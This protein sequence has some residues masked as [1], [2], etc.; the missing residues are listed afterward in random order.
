MLFSVAGLIVIAFFLWR[1]ESEAYDTQ[2]QIANN[3]DQ[4]QGS[5]ICTG[6]LTIKNKEAGI[7]TGM[8]KRGT[9]YRLHMDTEKIS[10]NERYSF[11]GQISGDG[12][13]RVISYQHHPYRILKYLVSASSLFIIIYLVIVHIRFNRS[14]LSLI[15]VN[16]DR[17]LFAWKKDAVKNA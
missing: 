13:L 7:V 10:L 5:I 9:Q 3:L 11:R 16:P 17:G 1:N 15:V 2:T 4:H 6:F 8:D 12:S 14:S